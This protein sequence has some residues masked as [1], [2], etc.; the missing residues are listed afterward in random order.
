MNKYI[1]INSKILELNNYID[2]DLLTNKYININKK[3]YIIA[4][5]IPNENY[6]LINKK[7]LNYEHG[8]ITNYNVYRY[9]NNIFFSNDKNDENKY[10]K[11]N[12]ISLKNLYNK[13]NININTIVSD[14]YHCIKVF[15]DEYLDSY[16]LNDLHTIIFKQNLKIEYI[17]NN[18]NN[19]LKKNNFVNIYNNN[20]WK[21]SVK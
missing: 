3:N 21:K 14:C 18:L 13:Y 12:N 4:G 11:I 6:D 20:I 16:L 9:H 2:I 15:L 5:L 17:D 19:M 7:G 1:D 10:C 8:I